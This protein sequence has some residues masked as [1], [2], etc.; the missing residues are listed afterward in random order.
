MSVLAA[1]HAPKRLKREKI[2]GPED[3]GGKMMGP[4]SAACIRNKI[5]DKRQKAKDKKQRV[6]DEGEKYEKC[7]EHK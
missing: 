5:K 7:F 2:S 4:K 3:G 1:N 6:T